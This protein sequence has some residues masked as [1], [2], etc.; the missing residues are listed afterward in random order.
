LENEKNL[1][2]I[3]FG[4]ESV[5]LIPKNSDLVREV[6]LSFHQERVKGEA[7]MWFK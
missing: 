6:G 7:P 2:I 3:D 4:W 1:E 5:R